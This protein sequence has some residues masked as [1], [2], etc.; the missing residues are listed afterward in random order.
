M[1]SIVATCLSLS[2]FNSFDTSNGPPSKG[3]FTPDLMY[4]ECIGLGR[5]P[6]SL[7]TLAPPPSLSFQW[8]GHR[9]M[10][11]QLKGTVKYL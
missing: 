9:Q 4:N 6:P 7:T 3:Y 1:K 8:L 5:N 11:Y 2:V 10:F